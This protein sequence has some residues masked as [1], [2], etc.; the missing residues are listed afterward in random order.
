MINCPTEKST[1]SY[2]MT[3][4]SF[5]AVKRLTT[6]CWDN[7]AAG[8]WRNNINQ[9]LT[10]RIWFFLLEATKQSNFTELKFSGDW[11]ISKEFYP[12]IK[13]TE[14]TKTCIPDKTIWISEFLFY[15]SSLIIIPP[16]F[17]HQFLARWSGG[18]SYIILEVREKDELVRRF[19]VACVCV[20]YVMDDLYLL[21]P[22][23]KH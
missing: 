17:P 3:R 21:N 18:N 7:G 16:N 8:G 12:H 11:H 5:T 22:P 23:E 2:F 9:I 10:F 20:T 19:S 14:W 6:V 4:K 1:G 15:P 13:T